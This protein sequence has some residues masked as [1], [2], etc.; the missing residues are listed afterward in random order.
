[1]KAKS[2]EAS[3][4]VEGAVEVECR[5]NSFRYIYHN[6]RQRYKDNDGIGRLPSFGR[7][8]GAMMPGE[9]TWVRRP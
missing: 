6:L 8:C 4:A 5:T 2:E 9:E 1:M 7:A 3:S